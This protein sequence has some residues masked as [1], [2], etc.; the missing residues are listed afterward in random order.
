VAKP[1]F[2]FTNDLPTPEE[3]QGDIVSRVAGRVGKRQ[4]ER[5][6]EVIEEDF[7]E[8]DFRGAAFAAKHSP[9]L[10]A[11]QDTTSQAKDNITDSTEGL[12]TEPTIALTKP[13]ASDSTIVLQKNK[14]NKVRRTR[15]M[16]RNHPE[17]GYNT[18]DSTLVLSGDSAKDSTIANTNYRDK[19]SAVV[20]EVVSMTA[21]TIILGPIEKA[22]I[23]VMMQEIPDK[24]IKAA[25]TTTSVRISSA[26]WERAKLIKEFLKVDLQDVLANA[27]MEYAK[28][29]A[30]GDVQRKDE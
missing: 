29:V 21:S 20:S 14:R 27:I 26:A 9:T 4:P 2:S 3:A 13:S 25:Y 10:Q 30:R 28:M 12:T 17:V 23:E 22:M 15:S 8:E 1:T 18:I 16:P 7:T 5:P 19:A 24:E 11:Y 6:V